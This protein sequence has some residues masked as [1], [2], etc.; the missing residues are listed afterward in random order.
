MAR[1]DFL[2]L[3]MFPELAQAGTFKVKGMGL[4]PP[5]VQERREKRLK[6]VITLDSKST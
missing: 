5:V 1:Q 6:P 4:H 2:S 3:P